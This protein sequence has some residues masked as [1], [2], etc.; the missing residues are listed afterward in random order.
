M[1]LVAADS[2]YVAEL[3]AWSRARLAA[4]TAED[5]W[6]NLTDRLEI[7]P[8][9]W[10]VGSGPGNDLVL[11]VGPE[12]LGV[13]E[14]A[15]DGAARFETEAGPQAFAPVPG[16]APR[17]RLG[18]LLLEATDLEGH[19]A[20][21]VRDAASPA[22]AAFPGI[23]RFPTD[24]A[25][26]LLA[27]WEALAEP[28]DLAINTAIGVKTSA[29]LTHLARFAHEGREV[30]LLP[31]HWRGEKPIFTFR[32]RTAGRE[33]YAASRFLL[34]EPQAGGRILLDFN[35]AYNPPCAFTAL[36]TCPLPPPRNVLP[37]E[38]RAGELKP[39]SV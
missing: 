24:P 11:S 38:I 35:K 17:L 33:T 26:R 23:D 8:G 19:R 22:R 18:D 34:G 16:G 3:E 31:T 1:A 6:L 29:K 27:A 28:E 12:H 9:R 20:L 25:W 2:D 10:S 39:K 4:L 15:P 30:E 5:G 36:A 13:L 37:F 14:L 32:D 7:E 21:R